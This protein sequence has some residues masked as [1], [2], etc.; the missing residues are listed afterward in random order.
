[1]VT[2]TKFVNMLEPI[3]VLPRLLILIPPLA[4]REQCTFDEASILLKI[5]SDISK[6]GIAGILTIQRPISKNQ[7]SVFLT[8]FLKELFTEGRMDFAMTKARMALQGDDAM[9]SPVLLSRMR[10]GRFWYIPGFIN[11][12]DAGKTWK[13]IIKKIKDDKKCT[14]I[15]GPWLSQRISRPRREIALKWADKYHYPMA[16][17]ERISIQKVAQ[18]VSA[19][20]SEDTMRNELKNEIRDFIIDNYGNSIDADKKNKTVDDLSCA[21]GEAIMEGNRK[22][23]YILL[24]GLELSVYIS[25]NVNRHLAIAFKK[26]KEEIIVSEKIFSVTDDVS[27]EYETEHDIEYDQKK[28][29]IYYLFGRLDDLDSVL[30]TEDDFL[31]FLIQFTEK[32]NELPT[33]IKTALTTSSLLFLGMQLHDLEFRIFFRCLMSMQGKKIF[34]KHRHVAVQIEPDDDFIFDPERA[35]Q[36]I[37]NYMDELAGKNISIYW[38][39]AEDFLKELDDRIERIR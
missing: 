37:I 34:R 35:R 3:F 2:A 9:W 7:W 15:I 38:G 1:M 14:P 32:R 5:A 10:T 4:N 24:A 20:E 22:D 21:A 13:D 29:M 17:H 27:R 6:S 23:P 30:L 18:Y 11:H 16:L 19:D 28:S 26:N 25:M 8:T 12:R 36:Y 39:S 33:E 31:K